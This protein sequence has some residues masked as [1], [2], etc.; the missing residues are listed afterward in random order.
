V[1]SNLWGKEGLSRFI[2]SLDLTHVGT[3]AIESVLFFSFFLGEGV[4]GIVD[5]KSSTYW[6]LSHGQWL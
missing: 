6:I 3:S 5:D 4:E 1:G 2:P